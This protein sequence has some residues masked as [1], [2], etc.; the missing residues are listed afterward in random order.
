MLCVLLGEGTV[1]RG[2]SRPSDLESSERLSGG[3]GGKQRAAGQRA[4]S[5]R[6]LRMLEAR[7]I[8]HSADSQK[9]N[10]SL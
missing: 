5:Q 1:F 7:F 10:I 9:T 4:A 2:G 8:A 6:A 3:R